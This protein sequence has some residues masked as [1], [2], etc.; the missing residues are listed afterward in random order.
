MKKGKN[1]FFVF[2]FPSTIYRLP[3][4]TILKSSEFGAA[5]SHCFSGKNGPSPVSYLISACLRALFQNID[6]Y[7]LYLRSGPLKYLRQGFC[8]CVKRNR[9]RQG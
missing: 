1:L 4:Q 6:V 9:S 3:S 7:L 8:Y 5:H 2:V